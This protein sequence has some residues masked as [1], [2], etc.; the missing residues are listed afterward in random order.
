MKTW[1]IS[2]Q[3]SSR[4]LSNHNKQGLPGVNFIFYPTCEESSYCV[5]IT[6]C[7]KPIW[8]RVRIPRPPPLPLVLL[9]ILPQSCTGL[10][11]REI[12]S[13]ECEHGDVYMQ[14]PLIKRA[15]TERTMC[16]DTLRDTHTHWEWDRR[17]RQTLWS[18]E[19]AELLWGRANTLLHLNKWVTPDLIYTHIHIHSFIPVWWPCHYSS[20]TVIN[21]SITWCD[22][23][24]Y[25]KYI[26]LN[27]LNVVFHRIYDN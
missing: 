12:R 7:L 24:L 11:E 3:L 23:I 10:Q 27:H 15:A 22:V 2:I 21:G 4:T 13:S 1:R 8:Q 20:N 5:Y 17:E 6:V 18:D 9:L 25:V 26:H 19:V 16:W 14:G